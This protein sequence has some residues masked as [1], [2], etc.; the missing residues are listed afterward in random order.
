MSADYAQMLKDPRWQR[1]RLEILQRDEFRCQGCWADDKTLHVD[2]RRYNWGHPPWDVDDDDLQTVCEDCH[3]TLT[4]LR[5]LVR[6]AVPVLDQGELGALVG[7]ITGL[8]VLRA[9]QHDRKQPVTGHHE[10]EG[11][12]HAFGLTRYAAEVL[13]ERAGGT[14]SANEM[15]AEVNRLGR[16][17]EGRGR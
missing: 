7:Y 14:V 9:G 10:T 17:Q 1:R 12:A 13:I 16:E 5:K 4:R 11:F 8:L 2:H 3:A 15:I 6:S